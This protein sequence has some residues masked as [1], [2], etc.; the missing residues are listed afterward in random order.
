MF[1]GCIAYTH[2]RSSQAL[3]MNASPHPRNMVWTMFRHC[4]SLVGPDLAGGPI[5]A[6]SGCRV[7]RL[8]WLVGLVHLGGGHERHLT[9]HH[10]CSCMIAMHCHASQPSMTLYT[11]ILRDCSSILRF[12]K[13]WCI[14]VHQAEVRADCAQQGL[15]SARHSPLFMGC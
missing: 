3:G 10:T 11:P 2:S 12:S 4:Q 1:R 6:Q 8:R 14:A 7:Q 13:N 15:K 9:E 5:D